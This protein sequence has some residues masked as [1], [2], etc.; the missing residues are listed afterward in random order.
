MLSSIEPLDPLRI[1]F[2]WP[3]ILRGLTDIIRRAKGHTRWWPEDVYAA[4]QFRAATCYLSRIEV[5]PVGYFIAHPQPVPFAGETELFIWIAWN[6]PPRERNGLRVDIAMVE[7]IRFLAQQA[8]AQNFCGLSTVTVRKGF[9]KRYGDFFTSHV[10]SCMMSA[11][12]MRRVAAEDVDGQR[13][14]PD[15]H[16]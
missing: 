2:H 5:T 4:I 1:H 8:V 11:E 7:G 10:Q 3:F 15:Q 13:R 16:D 12:T 9:L 6:I 14:Q